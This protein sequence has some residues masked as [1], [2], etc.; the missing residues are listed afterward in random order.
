MYLA[1]LDLEIKIDGDSGN[2]YPISIVH[3]P[4][5]EAQ[6]IMQLPFSELELQNRLLILENALLR[7]GGRIRRILSP[8]EQ[9]VRDFGAV[10]F[11]SLF[12]GDLRSI[13]YESRRISESKD[14]GLRVK[15]RINPTE[16][17]VLPWEY[18]YDARN[19]EYVCLSTKTPIVRYLEVSHPIRPL[20]ITPPVR[21]L[22]ITADLQHHSESQIDIASEKRRIHNAIKQLA[23]KNLVEITWIENGTWRDLLFQMRHGPWHILHFIGHGGYDVQNDE[24]MI[25]LPNADGKPEE[26]SAT[27]FAR[28]L[29]DH[30]AL[31]LVVLNACEGARNS[32]RQNFS[33]TAATLIKRGIPAVL[34]MQYSITDLG[35]I[36]FAQTFYEALADSL[37]IDAAVAEA[38]KAISL[39]VNNSLEWGTPVLYLRAPNGILFEIER[40]SLSSHHQASEIEEQAKV[41][42]ERKVSEAEQPEASSLRIMKASAHYVLPPIDKILTDW[43]RHQHNHDEVRKVGRILQETL[44]ALGVPSDFEG[45]YTGPVVTQYLMR[46]G[47]IERTVNGENR[48]AKIE[49]KKDS[50]VSQRFGT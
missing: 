10:L 31:R 46:P 29:A 30:S 49:V 9:A 15:L 47:Y 40:I 33:S 45:A 23:E 18:L 35:A 12:E 44:I 8:E 25:I 34:A 42:T 3:S 20:K 1:Y 27:K 32:Q 6:S 48:W 7:S 14:H 43:K 17:A 5:G 39:A 28:V 11:D 26:M 22:G 41:A 37:P 19:A 16:L 2:G 36:E 50:R 38:R 13:Y 4:A 24:G 21:I